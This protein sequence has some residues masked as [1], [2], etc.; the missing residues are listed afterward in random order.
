MYSYSPVWVNSDNIHFRLNH[1]K[2]DNLSL[3]HYAVSLKIIL[4]R[5]N[6]QPDFSD[7]Q[8]HIS[9]ATKR[10]PRLWGRDLINGLFIRSLAFSVLPLT[11]L[12]FWPRIA[13]C[14]L[15]DCLRFCRFFGTI[16]CGNLSV[17]LWYLFF[18]IFDICVMY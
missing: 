2:A 13:S 10:T 6:C 12:L 3:F 18:K 17:H 9:R 11:I 4:C 15:T 16:E 5:H 14:L 7:L 1:I 8:I